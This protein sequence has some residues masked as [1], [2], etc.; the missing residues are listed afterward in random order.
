LA[1]SIIR[2][3][4]QNDTQE[5][6]Q[7]NARAL[8]RGMFE[9]IP[10]KDRDNLEVFADFLK[11]T[12]DA[13]R[14]QLERT[15]APAAIIDPGAHDTGGGTG[16]IGVTDAAIE[17]F[18]YMPRRNQTN[19]VWSARQ[20]AR[21]PRGWI[22]LT[23]DPTTKD[24]VQ[25]LQGIWLDCLVRWLM[26]R[27]Y[28]AP[29][30]WIFAEEC[31][32]MGYQ[33]Q[34]KVLATQGRKRHLTLVM[35]AQSVS[36]LREIYGHEGAITL[37]SAPST[38]VILRVDET[39]MAEWASQQLG[40]HEVERLQMTQL[41]GLSQY[42]EG[43]N[44]QPQRTIERLILSDEIKLLPRLHGYLC[45][46]GHDRTSITIPER[47]PA[48]GQPALIARTYDSATARTPTTAHKTTKDGWQGL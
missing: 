45:I 30:V 24:A 1:A 27:R 7:R 25:A 11:Q 36:Q 40:E 48:T 43:V 4:P 41:A 37:I 10:V 13:L 29:H 46:A 42:R 6:F 14:A 38:K 21:E 17:G 33:P 20:W 31:P 3:R 18:G 35:C 2:G 44:L 9:A 15:K 47:L 28:N 16:I 26:D 5:Y 12:R 8:V 23:S 22:F 19:R 32:A 39:E 34:L